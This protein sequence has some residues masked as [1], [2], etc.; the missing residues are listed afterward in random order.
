M[1]FGLGVIFRFGRFRA[2]TY[3]ILS[4]YKVNGQ[5]NKKKK[6]KDGVH[7]RTWH[8]R[9]CPVASFTEHHHSHHLLRFQLSKSNEI[10][11]EHPP[12]PWQKKNIAVTKSK[13]I[14]AQIRKK[15][16]HDGYNTA[17]YYMP[18]QCVCVCICHP[19]SRRWTDGT[20][21]TFVLHNTIAIYIFSYFFIELKK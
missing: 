17:H 20:I 18:V 9:S 11:K 10:N 19:M 14:Y 3:R 6:K 5:W 2:Y 4:H 12:N 7:G 8:A 16:N 1:S 21:G 13:H 15:K